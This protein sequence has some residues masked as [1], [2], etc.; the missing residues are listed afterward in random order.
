MDREQL[1]R[2]LAEEASGQD[3]AAD[4]AFA[5]LFAAVPKVQ[6]NPAFVE[7]AVTAAWRWR[8]RRRRLVA[9]AW[10]A[11]VLLVVAGVGLAYF[12]APRL[13]TS[14]IKAMAFVSGR[15]VPWLVAYTTVAMGWWWTLGH[16]GGVIASAVMTP[17]RVV[18]VV[19]VELVG[20]LAFY[21]LQRIAGAE[22]LGD[23]QV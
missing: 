14:L 17:A 2:W 19:G 7:Q 18:A 12:G 10:V 21:A 1:E 23:A 4:A 16:V 9:F 5:H 13:V 8:V 11:T 6:A 3:A 15:A 20:I 22:R